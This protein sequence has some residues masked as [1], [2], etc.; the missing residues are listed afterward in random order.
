LLTGDDLSIQLFIGATAIAILGVA[1]TQ[2]GWTHK[3]FVW[4]LFVIAGGLSLLAVF[5]K[6]I[7]D[8]H[9]EIGPVASEVAGS[10]ISWFTLLLVGF[11]VVFFLDLLARTGWL[12]Q[13][14][15]TTVQESHRDIDKSRDKI[16]EPEPPKERVFIAVD[17]E[18]LMAFYDERT[19]VQ[20]DQLAQNYIGK[21]IRVSGNVGNASIKWSSVI[22]TLRLP[23]MRH[24]LLVFDEGWKER[25]SLLIGGQKITAIGEIKQV[26][27]DNIT[28]DHCEVID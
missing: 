5:W 23:N 18:Y 13:P 2:A 15:H 11:G 17:P 27:D 19:S 12:V 9:P 16:T 25:V 28:L 24:I 10:S 14:Q 22:A 21:W 3:G 7:R 4:S 1:V 8:A 26:S 6:P 20:G